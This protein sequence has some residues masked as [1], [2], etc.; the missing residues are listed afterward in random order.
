MVDFLKGAKNILSGKY[1]NTEAPTSS[2]SRLDRINQCKIVVYQWAN[3][4]STDASILFN[5]FNPIAPS[6]P[7]SELA[8]SRSYDISN[9]IESFAYTKDI[10]S[11]SGS[12]QITLHNSFDWAKFLKPGQW[13]C[14]YLSG[15]GDLPLPQEN[16]VAKTSTLDAASSALGSLLSGSAGITQTPVLPLPPGPPS[17]DMQ[18]LGHKLRCVGIIQRVGIR[19]QTSPDGSVDISYV[20]TGKDHGAVYE[21][22]ELW[23]NGNNSDAAGFAAAVKSVSQQFVRN[24]TELLNQYHSIFLN[25][26]DTLAKNLTSASAFFP[27]QWVMPDRLIQDLGLSLENGSGHFGDIKGLT[28]FSATVFENPMQDPLAGLDG[29]C[30]DRLKSI[31]QPEYHELFTE[32]S[33]GGHP[34]LIFRPIPWATNKSRYPVSGKLILS[35]ADLASPGPV[36]PPLPAGAIFSN[37]TSIDSF[38]SAVSAASSLLG[39]TDPHL[40]MQHSIPL[41]SPWVESFDIGPDYHSRSNFFYVDAATGMQDSNNAWALIG[42]S[43]V[44]VF[45]FRDENDIKRH[46]FRPTFVNVHSFL[47]TNVEFFGNETYK[48]FMLELNAILQ[49]YHSNAEDLYS[50]SFNLAAGKNSVK[51]GKVFVTDDTFKAVGRMAFYI[52]GYTD[53]F[54]VDGDG[55]CTWTQSV[56]VTRGT[57][58]SSLAGGGTKNKAPT[59]SSTFHTRAESKIGDSLLDKTKNAIKDPKSLFKG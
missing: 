23:F 43:P 15:D 9:H 34:K 27:E 19:S 7:A 39:P 36:P 33:D 59:Q 35:Y 12:F 28:E 25:P 55:A 45:P 38:S 3:G 54:Y 42:K 20:V 40:R 5:N 26:S 2:D 8:K 41:S 32:L 52:E 6:S 21:E 10:A 58:L 37:L 11:A 49:D 51:L 24:L 48:D 44:P 14:V 13:L 4:L 53:N 22:T 29:R 47:V 56:T 57:E 50:G 30:W 17:K 31:S 16:N 1:P 46:G 18:A